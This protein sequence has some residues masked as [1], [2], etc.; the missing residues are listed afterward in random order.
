MWSARCGNC[1]TSVLPSGGTGRRY[2]SCLF[3]A[4]TSCPPHGGESGPIK[5]IML[6]RVLFILFIIASSSV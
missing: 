3:V 2:V 4:A 5:I 6:G 1:N